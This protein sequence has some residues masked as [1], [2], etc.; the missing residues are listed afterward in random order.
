[1]KKRLGPQEMEDKMIQEILDNFDFNKCWTVMKLINWTWGF[2]N[3][4]PTISKLKESA[5][6]R[7]KSAVEQAKKGEKIDVYFSS[8]GGLK[9]SAWRNRYHQIEGIKLEFVLTDWDTDGDE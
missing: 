2:N 8:S 3:E 9:G 4:T 1:M 6:A 5:V 7:L